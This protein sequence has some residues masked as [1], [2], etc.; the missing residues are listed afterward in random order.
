MNLW[1]YFVDG[2][3][4]AIFDRKAI[5][6]IS[7]DAQAT[8]PAIILFSAGIIL[9][10]IGEIIK[11]TSETRPLL[12]FT[13]PTFPVLALLFILSFHW[14]AKLFG[15][16]P[17]F[18]NFFRPLGI[19]LL[20][21]IIALAI[22]FFPMPFSIALTILFGIWALTALIFIIK[23]AYQVSLGKSIGILLT[24]LLSFM[25]IVVILFI[26]IFGI[27]F[28]SGVGKFPAFTK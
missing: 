27:I 19:T 9:Q 4:I 22:P 7:N 18:L 2:I 13:L 24:A 10:I 20:F 25:V 8:T 3:K 17:G 12:A 11:S 5:R 1:N 15:S 14:M 26:I 6:R 28:I 23:E 21:D 16:S